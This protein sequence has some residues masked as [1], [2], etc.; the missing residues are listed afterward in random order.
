MIS[1]SWCRV[2]RLIEV[3]RQAAEHMP[4]AMH[5]PGSTV[6]A[7]INPDLPLCLDQ[8]DRLVGQTSTHMPQATQV[9]I[10]TTAEDWGFHTPARPRGFHRVNHPE[11][12]IF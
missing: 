11:I 9:K 10:S 8:A 6:A 5:F 1:L 12:W 3:E 7:G 4:Q 2:G